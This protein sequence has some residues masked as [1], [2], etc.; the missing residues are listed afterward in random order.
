MET[1]TRNDSAVIIFKH[2]LL[3]QWFGA[4]SMELRKKRSISL[5]E[6]TQI[7][8][9]WLVEKSDTRKKPIF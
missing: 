6:Q 5:K 1:V 9:K 2:L 3:S 7:I 4:V 8:V